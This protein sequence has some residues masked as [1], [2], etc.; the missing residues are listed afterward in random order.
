MRADALGL[1]WEDKPAEKSVKVEKVKREPPEPT[2]LLP[3]YLPY[4]EESL[5][6]NVPLM[7]D[8]EIIECVS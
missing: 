7:T 8:Q 2:W 1:F 5:A 6:F 4:L 3:D